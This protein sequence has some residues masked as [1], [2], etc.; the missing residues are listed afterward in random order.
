MFTLSLLL[1]PL[2]YIV[3]LIGL[4]VYR[5]W[6]HPLS[7]FPGPKAAAVSEYW[8]A[9]WNIWPHKGG[10]LFEVERLHGVHGAAVRMGPNEIHVNDP[11]YYH[12][13][14]RL[15]SRY[16]KDPEMHKV[17]GAPSSTVA[18]TDPVLHKIRRG[19]LEQ[20][21]SRQ[22]ILKLEPMVMGKVERWSNKLEEHFQAGKP[23]PMEFALKSLTMD[24]VTTF[25]FGQEFGAVE[26]PGFM[27]I[28]VRLFRNYLMSLHVIKAFPFVKLLQ[29]L[30]YFIARHISSSVEMGRHL[31]DLSD[32]HINSFVD[33]WQNGDK[34]NFPT[35]I[36]RLLTPN[37]DKGFQVPSKQGIKDEVI[38]LVSAGNDTTGITSMVG[39]FQ[40]LSNPK[41]YDR[42]LAELKT[43]LPKVDSVAPYTELEKLPYLTACIKESLRYAS[44]AASRTPRLVPPGGIYLPDGR[45]VPAGTRIGMAIYL[46]HFNPDLFPNPRVFDPERWLRDP[47]EMTVQNKFLVPF[48]KGSRACLG[49]NLAHMELYTIMAYLI[50]RHDLKL[51][52]TTAKD[53]EWWDMVIPEFKGTFKAWTGKRTE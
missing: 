12:E 5:I 45:F 8:E 7:K 15:G 23:V 10:C 18:E 51:Y 16:Y 43:I 31:E 53:M 36:G 1:L 47:A 37:E 39:L 11:R 24:M 32:G 44:A 26:D 35:V 22:S 6:F 33:K 3:Y 50:R 41:I 9:W 13:L 48:S 42:L 21:F 20:L 29:G 34:P 46:I 19:A 27:S 52:N 2:G 40:I 14:Y 17:L 25:A 38:T 4:A 30:P 28:P 49:I